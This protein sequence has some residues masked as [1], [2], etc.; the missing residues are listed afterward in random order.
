[1][2]E[3]LR[4]LGVWGRMR[5]R[6]LPISEPKTTNTTTHVENIPQDQSTLTLGEQAS[7]DT[8]PVSFLVQDHDH[9]ERMKKIE[10]IIDWASKHKRTVVLI[11]G[12]AGI[13]VGFVG[14]AWMFKH[15]KG[16]KGVEIIEPEIK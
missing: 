8:M 10:P 15:F 13:V 2:S 1:M 14:L 4:Y 6:I 11:S 16:R 9:E 7:P 3:N 5:G 12:A